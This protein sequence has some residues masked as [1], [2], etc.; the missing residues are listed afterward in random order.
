MPNK[1]DRTPDFSRGTD[2]E[3]RFRISLPAGRYYLGAVKRMS[4]DRFGV[5]QVGDYVL[6]QHD[7][8]GLL[9]QYWVRSGDVLDVGSIAGATPV[10]AQDLAKR[11]AKT[12]ITGVVVDTNGAPVGNAV[13]I[14][15]V[16]PSVKGKPLFISESSK[17]DGKYLLRLTPGTYYL[18]ARNNLTG[19]PPEPGQIVGYYGEGEPAPVE[20]KEGETVRDI[21]FTDILFEGRGPRPQAGQ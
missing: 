14:A 3:G 6:L 21:D 4:G 19:G 1:Y 11:S 20:V 8:K 5:P 10:R 15:Y 13:V 12:A 2:G 16:D 17:K 9:K 7:E 18:R